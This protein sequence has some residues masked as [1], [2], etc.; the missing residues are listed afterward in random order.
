VAWAF[1]TSRDAVGGVSSYSG[2]DTVGPVDGWTVA[3]G[4][5]ATASAPAVATTNRGAAVL[6]TYTF[7]RSTSIG[8]PTV[9]TDSTTTKRWDQ[10]KSFYTA[11]SADAALVQAG[12]TQPKPATLST[13]S[14]GWL[15][16]T[17]ALRNARPNGTVAARYWV[18]A[19]D[20]D[21]AENP[22]EGTASSTVD[23]YA[24]NRPPAPITSA[25][26]CTKKADGSSQLGWT[27]P[28]QPGDVDSGDNIAFTRVYRDGTRFD[29]TTIGTDNTWNDG[30]PGGT[31]TYRLR[32]V[33]TH[34][35][36]SAAS[37]SVT[38]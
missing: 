14:T 23:A 25:V 20:R 27:Q 18:V 19:L 38:C 36:E 24:V 5:S 21:T 15:A 13:A 16:Q 33:D 31:H 35:A 28:A 32:N 1:T 12:T 29:R 30:Q 17:I 34:L 9:T 22:R 8:N 11:G 37:A 2:V 7:V 6:S 10:S 3:D 26:T 4:T